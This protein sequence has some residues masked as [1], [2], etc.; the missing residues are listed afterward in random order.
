MQ[1]N[2]LA[3]AFVALAAP[4]IGAA[5]PALATMQRAPVAPS[6]AIVLVEDQS[7]AQRFK[8]EQMQRQQMM[9]REKAAMRR[10][11]IK[12]EEQKIIGTARRYLHEYEQSSGGTR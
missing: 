3:A 11:M 10:E 12:R 5:N 6:T 7:D 1:T 2:I 8:Q 9:Q 4:L